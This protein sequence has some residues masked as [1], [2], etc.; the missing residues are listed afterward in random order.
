MKEPLR[1]LDD[2]RA[3]ASL[4]EVL[5][6][7]PRAPQLPPEV[8]ARAMAQAVELATAGALAKAAAST[9]STIHGL[10][11]SGG[12]KAKLIFA[13]SVVGAAG[14]TAYLTTRARSPGDPV[15]GASVMGSA[16]ATLSDRAPL[17]TLAP[18]AVADKPGPAPSATPRSLPANASSRLLEQG[19][20]SS[21]LPPVAA[22][23]DPGLADEARVLESARSALASNPAQ[24]LEIANRHQRLYPAGQLSAEREFI[25]IDALLRLG[26]RDEAERRAAPRLAQAPGSLYARRLRQLLGAEAP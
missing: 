8:H 17:P 26:R 9:G 20:R 13:L 19:P 16:R 12:A 5:R 18:P 3:A 1:W 7:A 4:R 25:A 22:F 24:A 21:T 14:T 15:R 11:S 6:A 23:E 2:E 10:L